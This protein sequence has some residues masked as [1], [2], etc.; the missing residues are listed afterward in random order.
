MLEFGYRYT[1][2]YLDDG[3]IIYELT[4]NAHEMIHD[5]LIFKNLNP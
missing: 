5:Y 2:G 3:P 4:L 1:F